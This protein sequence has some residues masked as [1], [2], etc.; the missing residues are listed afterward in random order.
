MDEQI[1]ITNL[2]E[3]FVFFIYLFPH[4]DLVY[5]LKDYIRWFNFVESFVPRSHSH[6][7]LFSFIP[8]YWAFTSKQMIR[9]S[10]AAVCI[11]MRKRIRDWLSV[12]SR[13]CVHGWR[14]TGVGSIRTKQSSP[15]S[16]RDSNSRIGIAINCHRCRKLWCQTH[17]SETSYSVYR[18]NHKFASSL[19]R[20]S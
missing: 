4:V 6:A 8:S 13:Q 16:A 10:T 9:S 14:Q 7:V 11:R 20:Y 3:S 2:S 1:I 5:R 12:P 18:Q 15:V 17:T 19:D